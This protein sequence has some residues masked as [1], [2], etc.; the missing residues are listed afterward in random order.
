MKILRIFSYIIVLLI[1]ILGLTFAAINANPVTIHYYVGTAQTNLSLLLVY[2]LGIGILL[3]LL[4]T[5]TT[6]YKLKRKI[7]LLKNQL[8]QAEKQLA[9]KT[10]LPSDKPSEQP[11]LEQSP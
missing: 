9:A 4:S 7:R 10:D 6:I 5:I 2:A 3:G 1:I 8:K 11:H